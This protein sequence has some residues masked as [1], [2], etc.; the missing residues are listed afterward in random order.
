MDEG[1]LNKC[2]RCSG[3][4]YTSDN[5]GAQLKWEKHSLTAVDYTNHEGPKLSLK[6]FKFNLQLCET[7]QIQEAPKML[8]L[9]WLRVD[10]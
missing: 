2:D 3:L 5:N 1:V 9:R 8:P 4:N 10:T 6:N 7:E